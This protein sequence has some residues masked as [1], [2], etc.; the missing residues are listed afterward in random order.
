MNYEQ[1]KRRFL[2]T[3]E[4]YVIVGKEGFSYILQS[5]TGQRRTF[6]R[7]RLVPLQPGEDKIYAPADNFPQMSS[8]YEVAKI[9]DFDV[10]TQKYQVYWTGWKDPT[11]EPISNIRLKNPNQRT[12][13]EKAFWNSNKGRKIWK[14]FNNH[15]PPNL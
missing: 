15:P 12:E 11:W 13:A 8:Y 7:W 14:T 3:P 9:S 10:A 4:H 1:K 6:S 5:A 2:V